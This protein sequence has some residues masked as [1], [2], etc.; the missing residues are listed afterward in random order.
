M[1]TDSTFREIAD[2]MRAT[3]GLAL[4]PSKKSLVAARLAP[5]LQ[6]LELATYEDYLTRL[7]REHDDGEL[8]VA[9]DLLTTN[10]T[11]FFR[12]APHFALLERDLARGG[13]AAPAVWSAAS[14]FGDEAYSIAM[15]LADLE[16][17]GHIG[18][19][20]SVLGTDISDRVLRAAQAAIF[21]QER[22]REVSPERLRRYC[23][24]GDG[25]FEGLAKM[26]P[27]LTRRVHFGWLNLFEPIEPLGPFDAIFL[28]NVLIY[29][30]VPTRRAVVERVLQRLKPGGL[31]FIGM[32][33]GRIEIGSRLQVLGP[34]AFRKL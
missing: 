7:L 33:E 26:Q 17:R 13:V 6:R 10:E 11:Y 1:L 9:I 19:G 28:R 16:S 32:A 2:L 22:L 8:Q 21:P 31:F 4:P 30:D 29:F 5:R 23:L 14:S 15:V 18:R 24:R 27:A 12:E 34:G 20:W 25:D 3:I